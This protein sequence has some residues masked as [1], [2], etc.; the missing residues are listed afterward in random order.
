VPREEQHG[1]LHVVTPAGCCCRHGIHEILKPDSICASPSGGTA[2]RQAG[3]ITG[4]MAAPVK[5]P[6]LSGLMLCDP[7]ISH[8]WCARMYSLE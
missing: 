3:G 8:S 2:E 1:V 6:L 5:V 7:G 4:S